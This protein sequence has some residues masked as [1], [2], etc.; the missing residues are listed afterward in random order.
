MEN[1]FTIVKMVSTS[2]A[3]FVLALNVD[4]KYHTKEVCTTQPYDHG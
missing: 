1:G 3:I 4:P 2:V